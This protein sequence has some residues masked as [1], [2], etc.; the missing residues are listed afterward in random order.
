SGTVDGTLNI[1][2]ADPTDGGDPQVAINGLDGWGTHSTLTISFSL[3]VDENGD[4]VT[5]DSA[6][7]EAAGSIR[8]FETIMGGSD[9]S[10]GCA[11][12]HRP[13]V[14]CGV[15]VHLGHGEDFIVRATDP[16]GVAVIPSKQF[17]AKIGYMAVLTTDIL[18]SM[19]LSVEPSQTDDVMKRPV[20][21]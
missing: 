11:A 4:Q 10:E 15:A 1:P 21:T 8:V 13:A 5:V 14:T 17:K 12:A 18:D 7:L 3:P 19:G 16:S 9:V 20:S 6:S 2:V